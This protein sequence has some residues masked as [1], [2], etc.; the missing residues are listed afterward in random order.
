[1]L[2]AQ[3]RNYS[4]ASTLVDSLNSLAPQGRLLLAVA[5]KPEM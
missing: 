2:A 5:P 3:T 4:L 1:K